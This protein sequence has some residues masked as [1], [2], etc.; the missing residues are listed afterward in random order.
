[1]KHWPERALI[2]YASAASIE[3]ISGCRNEAPARKGIDTLTYESVLIP[4]PSRNRAQA[5]K[6]IDTS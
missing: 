5:R 3:G 2:P 1:M 4:F 6:G